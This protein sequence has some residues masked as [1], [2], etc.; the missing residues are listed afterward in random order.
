MSS[1]TDQNPKKTELPLQKGMPRDENPEIQDSLQ[2]FLT[3]WV[4]A[5]ERL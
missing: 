2:I 3:L 5:N 1:V 4:L